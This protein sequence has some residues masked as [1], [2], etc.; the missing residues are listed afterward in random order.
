[1]C[2]SRLNK[3]IK[4]AL[5]GTCTS[6]AVFSAQYGHGYGY[7][8]FYGDGYFELETQTRLITRKTTNA[9]AKRIS[10]NVSR[11]FSGTGGS[12]D[13][14]SDGLAFWGTSIISQI[15]EDDNGKAHRD[16][17]IYQF[18]GGF[19]KS[20]GDL[21]F[22]SALTYAYSEHEQAGLD[23]Y[24]NTIG[25]TPYVAYKLTDFMYTSALAGYNYTG[26]I[27]SGADTDIHDYYTEANLSVF[28]KINSFMLKGRAGVRYTH[29]FASI[30]TGGDN[31]SDELT[32]IGDAEVGYEFDNGLT[33]YTGVLF[34]HYD[35]EASGTGFSST[36]YHEGV[37]FM[38]WGADYPIADKI[39]IGANI[40]TD[41]NDHDSSLVSG[42]IN[43][44]MEM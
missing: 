1:M 15:T 40:E 38:R 28:K 11:V 19:D 4:G 35:R 29:S 14:S 36:A 21:F 42:G 22:G 8:S 24:S 44:R 12:S 20:V 17:D 41:L 32:W 23:S 33:T 27:A 5:I 16:N 37:F 7:E 9:I 10:A 6:I 31:S 26:A 43:I 3:V 2:K 25:V 34:E 18:I 39:S 13:S 30:K